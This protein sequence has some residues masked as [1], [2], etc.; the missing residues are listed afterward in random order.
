MTKSYRPYIKIKLSKWEFCLVLFHLAIIAMK[1]RYFVVR[2][3]EIP[4]IILTNSSKGTTQSKYFDTY[5]G[6][7]L[8]SWLMIVNIFFC[9]YVPKKGSLRGWQARS[10]SHD[11]AKAEKQYRVEI[12]N[13]LCISMLINLM[14]LINQIVAIETQIEFGVAGSS[15]FPLPQTVIAII[16]SRLIHHVLWTRL[17]DK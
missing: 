5:F 4:E 11:I 14:I 17:S 8:H 6:T 10:L 12:S 9:F 15:F 7:F 16:I 13:L 1:V 2:W 3:D